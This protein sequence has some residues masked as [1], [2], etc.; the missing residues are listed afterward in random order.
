MIQFPGNWSVTPPRH[1][2]ILR[3]SIPLTQ[4]EAAVCFPLFCLDTSCFPR[5]P[6]HE[7]QLPAGYRCFARA[8][9]R[10][11]SVSE[12]R[13]HSSKKAAKAAPA[14]Q[15]TF[16]WLCY[17]HSPAFPAHQKTLL[18]QLGGGRV[19]WLVQNRRD[20]VQCFYR[21]HGR[22]RLRL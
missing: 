1:Q 12:K 22:Q 16:P 2:S 7:K 9:L 3:L 6:G 4:H 5:I 10:M 20:S 15:N 14:S 13:E 17:T 18:N 8:P 11:S 19:S 21:R